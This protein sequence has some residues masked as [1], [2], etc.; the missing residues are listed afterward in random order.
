LLLENWKALEAMGCEGLV[1]RLKG[2][3]VKIPM[4]DNGEEIAY[5]ELESHWKE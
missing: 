2:E 5:S 3:R 4:T 1:F